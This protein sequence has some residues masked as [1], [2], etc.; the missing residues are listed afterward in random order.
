MYRLYAI[1]S[2]TFFLVQGSFA[3]SNATTKPVE[4]SKESKKRIKTELKEYLSNPQKYLADQ[5]EKKNKIKNAEK[6]LEEIKTGLR[7]EK[8][9]LEYARDSI[10]LMIA[11]IDE[12]KAAAAAKDTVVVTKETT[13]SG[14]CMKMPEK[15]IFYKV[16]L[17]NFATYT[18]S[19]FT[20]L[21]TFNTEIAPS[22][23]K[24]FVAGYFASLEEA[25]KFAA[26]IRILGIKGAFVTQYQ[27]GN[28]SES[29]DPTKVK[30]KFT[31]SETPKTEKKSTVS[32]PK[33]T[34]EKPAV[35]PKVNS[36]NAGFIKA[37]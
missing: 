37:K 22:G 3:Q 24:R 34:S 9:D 6:E 16:Q 4:L 33:S 12:L 8:R 20:G 27:D 5:E 36:P 7:I 28:R 15:G 26:D 1:L 18:P 19:G 11:Q 25:N 30:L 13:V 32:E 35:V 21:K 23:S 14:D 31:P 29:F 2:L 17:G 10:E